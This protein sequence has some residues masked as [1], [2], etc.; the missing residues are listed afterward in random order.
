MLVRFSTH[1]YV[2]SL[3]RQ[4]TALF[5]AFRDT[6]I[7]VHNHGFPVTSSTGSTGTAGSGDSAGQDE[8]QRAFLQT[9][10]EYF[11]Y[12]Y[13]LEPMIVVVT[14]EEELQTVFTS[15]TSHRA[16]IVGRVEGDF[17]A[18]SPRDLGKI[19]WPLVREAM[20]GSRERALRDLEI[21]ADAEKICGVENVGRQMNK[22]AGATL[23]V[24]EDYHVRGSISEA[25]GSATISPNVDVR[26][27]I[28]DVIDMLI[29][30]VL[31]SDGNVVFVPSGSLSEQGRIVLLLRETVGEW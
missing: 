13:D 2:I 20:S 3:N 9:V 26:D 22:T 21:A 27:E 31:G 15:V 12:Y 4:T 23:I 5:E 25:D 19:V 24:E 30:K 10:D 17:S 11:G 28:D 16:A 1:Y 7:D 29:E 8:G 18:T 14:G 6:L